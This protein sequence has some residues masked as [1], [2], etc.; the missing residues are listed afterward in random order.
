[1]IT[2]KEAR[3]EVKKGNRSKEKKQNGIGSWIP[4][5]VE[6]EGEIERKI[7]KSDIV[8]REKAY[9]WKKQ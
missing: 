2:N 6:I 4:M 7:R 5:E 8:S 1:M 3:E 9:G